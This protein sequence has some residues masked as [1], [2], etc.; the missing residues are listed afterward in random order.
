MSDDGQNPVTRDGAR[1][2]ALSRYSH[3]DVRDR[4]DADLLMA[5]FVDGAEWQASRKVEV[6]EAMILRAL[7]G[8]TPLAATPNLSDWSAESVSRMRAALEGTK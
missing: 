3:A 6:T 2:E 4:Y 5:G 7:N 1:A 8:F